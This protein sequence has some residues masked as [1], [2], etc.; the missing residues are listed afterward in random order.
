MTPAYGRI[1]QAQLPRERGA[2]NLPTAR[3]PHHRAVEASSNRSTKTSG[4]QLRRQRARLH[5]TKAQAHA[6]PWRRSLPASFGSKRASDALK[7]FHSSLTPILV[8]FPSRVSKGSRTHTSCFTG[9]RACQ[10]HHR[11]H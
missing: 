9:R 8:T 7:H 1:R 5:S 10:I 2:E 4:S 6:P 11:H 3:T